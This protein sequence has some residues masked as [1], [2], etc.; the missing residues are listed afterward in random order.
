[1]ATVHFQILSKKNP[2]NLY[3]RLLNG[4]K[5]DVRRSINVF[6]N[7]KYWDFKREII[8]NITSVKNRDF[9]N[10][11]LAQLKIEII[12]AYNSASIT[13]EIVDG[14]WM[15]SVIDNFFNRPKLDKTQKNKLDETPWYKKV[16]V[17]LLIVLTIL[18]VIYS[19]K[20]VK[21]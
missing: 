16:W 5:T 20:K 4:R 15:K 21:K 8:K 11:K 13:G 18:C 17:W 12:D 2:S 9:I 14:E 10:K 1:M 19:I 3:C 6:V 7:P